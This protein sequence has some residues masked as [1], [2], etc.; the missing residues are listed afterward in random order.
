VVGVVLGALPAGAQPDVAAATRADVPAQP[1]PAQRTP[2]QSTPASRPNLVVLMTDDQTLESM[3]VLPKVRA[4]LGDHGVT[5]SNFFANYPLCCPSR[6]TYFTGQYAHNHHVLY[7]RGSTGGFRHFEGQDTAFPVAL[8]RA[9]YH[10]IHIGKYLNGYGKGAAPARAPIPPGW[11]DWEASVDPSTYRYY[12]FTLNENGHPHRF[13]RHAYQTDVYANIAVQKIRQQAV[14]RAGDP[15]FLDV[16]FLAPHAV[17]RETSGLDRFDEAA[18]GYAHRRHGIRYPVPAPKYRDRFA[19]EPLPYSAA[20]DQAD[21]SAMPANIRDRPKFSRPEM[22]DI[23][24]DYRLRLASLLSVDDAVERIVDALRDTGALDRT[25]IV[26]MS[27]NGYFHGEHR[28]PFGKY[29]PYEPSIRV[30]LIIRGPGIASGM[31]ANALA[32]NVDIAP[33]ILQLTGATALRAEDGRSLVPVLQDPLHGEVHQEVL[34][35]SGKNDVGVPVYH[36][37]RTAR[38]KYVVYEDGDRELFDLQADPDEVRNLAGQRTM[39]PVEARL[40]A[41]LARVEACAGAA[42]P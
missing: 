5:F 16:A 32:S 41:K 29:L 31:T 7:N 36:G 17:E 4:L 33:T 2:A 8:Q 9:G 28:I 42:C 19:D 26:F 24:T 38:F 27:D 20:F 39:E 12:D 6:T 21:V 13:S 1:T 11:D 23:R 3:R 22:A 34:L 25:V 40:A 35:E 18:V 37:I 14:A 15:F 30:P 10:T